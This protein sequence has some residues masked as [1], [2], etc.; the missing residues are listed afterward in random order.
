MRSPILLGSS[1]SGIRPNV[2]RWP[3]DGHRG[4]ELATRLSCNL[5]N[6]VSMPTQLAVRAGLL[7]GWDCLHEEKN[8][9]VCN[10]LEILHRDECRRFVIIF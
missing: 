8:L 4:I 6:I 5:T 7:L 2:D 9:A 10:D 1:Q 3:R